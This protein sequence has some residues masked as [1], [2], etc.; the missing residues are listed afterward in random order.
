MTESLSADQKRRIIG[1]TP[2]GRLAS[3]DDISPVV[4]FLLS[5]RARFVTGQSI[6]VDGGITV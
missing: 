2:L 4:E 3:A 6:V 1:R 5:D